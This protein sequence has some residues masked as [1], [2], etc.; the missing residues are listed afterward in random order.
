MVSCDERSIVADVL[1]TINRRAIYLNRAT[2][3]RSRHAI[4]LD[5]DG[6]NR[7]DRYLE[8]IE[9]SVIKDHEGYEGKSGRHFSF[10]GQF[11]VII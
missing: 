1:K 5:R 6:D 3:H 10:K 8:P 7:E 11:L 2:Y 4:C 9:R